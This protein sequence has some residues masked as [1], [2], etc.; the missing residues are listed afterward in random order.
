MNVK[1]K[2]SLTRS[3]FIEILEEKELSI[4][5]ELINKLFWYIIIQ[6]RIFDDDYNGVIDYK[7]IAIGIDFLAEG[8]IEDKLER[9]SNY[10]L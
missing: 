5:S 2:P 10:F 3:Q 4:E 8:Y 7:E 1:T 9:K 6:I